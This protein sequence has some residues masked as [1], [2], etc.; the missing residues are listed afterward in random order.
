MEVPALINRV[1]SEG[2][3][4]LAAAVRAGWDAAVP[5]TEWN[6]RELVTH[7]GGI[8]RWAADIVTTCSDHAETAAGAA[9]GSGPD[10]DELAEWFE[11]GLIAL[12]ATLRAAPSDL[13]CFAF[14][15]ADSPLHF[16]SRRQAHETA[17]HR[18]DAEGAA[19]GDITLF[20]PAFAQDG[21]AEI[22]CGFGARKRYAVSRDA[23]LGL[24]AADGPSWLVT[25]GAEQIE[26]AESEDL[27]GTDVTVRGVSSDLYR[28]LW[29]RPSDAVVDGDESVAEL[30]SSTV[31]V[32]W[33]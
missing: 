18:V 21:M 12:V 22:L 24:D 27:V 5:R 28:W 30:W 7:T 11:N 3:L 10:D 25:F 26:A 6:V 31:R 14:L 33:R 32:S 16:W 8:H 23:T 20:E 4:L 15:P 9:V 17:I 13:E 2:N 29:N 19:G 1:E